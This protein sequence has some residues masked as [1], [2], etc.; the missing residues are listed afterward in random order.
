[1]KPFI[2]PEISVTGQKVL[3]FQ[4][5]NIEI[6]NIA[7][8]FKNLSIVGYSMPVDHSLQA[9]WI[10]RLIFD[11]GVALEFSAACTAVDGWQEVGSL[12]IR[13]I[14]KDDDEMPELDVPMVKK[15][16]PPF[17]VTSVAKLTYQDEHF[18]SECGIRFSTENEEEILVITGNSPGSVSVTTPFSTSP[19]KSEFLVAELER[20]FL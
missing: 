18:Q 15:E 11:T 2:T 5:E 17:R 6:K 3:R 19:L 8:W 14:D 16:L 12:N 20:I 10:F 4:C 7:Q 13:C 9:A 1:M